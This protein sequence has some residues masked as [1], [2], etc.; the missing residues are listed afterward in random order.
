M[1]RKSISI[2]LIAA[3]LA[4]GSTGCAT[5]NTT[6]SSGSGSV[7]EVTQA[8]QTDGIQIQLSNDKIT[9]DSNSVEISD[10][11]VTIT[12]AGTY[13]LSGELSDGRIVV[14]TDKDAEVE[15][16]LNGVTLTCS[17]YAPI[18]IVKA[19]TATITLADGT[20]NTLNDGATYDLEDEDDNTD[21]V[22][23][24]KDDLVLQGG[25]ALYINGAYKHGIVCKDNLEIKDGTYIIEAAEDGVNANDSL[26]VNGGIFHISAGD[27]GMHVDEIFT[28]NNGDITIAE[29]Y[30]G[31][32]GHQV[33]INNGT[34]TITSSDDGINSNS[35]SNSSS[36]TDS[37]QADVQTDA[38]A[39]AGQQSGNPPEMPD[40]TTPGGNSEMPEM[41]DGTTP[42]GNGE[43]PEMPDGTTPGGNGEMPEMPDGTT[44]G[45]NGE[46]PEMPDGT[47]PGANGEMQNGGIP[48]NGGGMIDMDADEE[49]LIQIN[50]GTITIN[51]G[52]DG[53]DSNGVLEVTGGT[54]YVSGAANNGDGALDYGISASITGGTVIAAGF[55]GMAEGFGSD[56]TQLS[57]L[58]NTSQTM[59]AGTEIIVKDSSG[60]VIL[61]WAP[62]KEFNSVVVSSPEFTSDE[63]YTIVIGD[64]EDSL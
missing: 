64:L 59:S 50:G 26:T 7:N 36:D 15:L 51:A 52:G 42:G 55:S 63:T 47:T 14:D 27:D 29:S 21:A 5:L 53:L 39:E 31:L 61:S 8:S 34:I 30:E 41:P 13:V 32:E 2:I 11:V 49:S 3:M 16:V 19:G 10:N 22:I 60:A 6:G 58:Y 4:M 20:E 56:S 48:G 28:V 44:P 40:G 24:S 17:N 1:R 43:M 9:T 12:E 54:V 35:G 25:G 38:Q 18:K 37:A 46:M 45:E 57:Y 33:I 23:F 62:D